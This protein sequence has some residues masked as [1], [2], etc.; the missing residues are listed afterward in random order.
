[1]LMGKITTEFFK[2]LERWFKISSQKNGAI[3]YAGD[4]NQKRSNRIEIFSWNDFQSLY[5]NY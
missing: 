4:E 2:G 3:I 1:M 5:S